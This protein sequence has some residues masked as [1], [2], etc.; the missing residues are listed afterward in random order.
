LLATLAAEH[1]IFVVL[2]AV[3]VYGATGDFNGAIG[4][5]VD[6]GAVVAHKYHGLTITGKEVFEP[7]DTL[8]IKMVGGLVEQENV[9]VLKQEFGKFD[10]H[11]P[12]ARKLGGGTIKIFAT[13][14][15]AYKGLLHLAW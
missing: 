5:I 4:D 3:V 1:Y 12:S 15:E 11:A 10:T 6:E 7:L 13:E 8:Y 2:N 14:A 9:G